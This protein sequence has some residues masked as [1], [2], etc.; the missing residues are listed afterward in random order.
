VTITVKV[1]SLG[2]WSTYPTASELY[3]E[4]S[5]YDSGSDAGRSTVASND[6]LSDI[7]TTVDSDSSSGQKVLNVASTTGFS[8]G[9][10]ILI[11][12]GGAR[13]E[14]G[15]VASIQAGVSL[16]LEDN[17]VYTHTA[18][19]GDDVA[20]EWFDFDVTMTPLRDGAIYINAYLK[21]YEASKGC[22]VNG[23]AVPV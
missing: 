10:E 8:V 21:K 18:A 2:V 13:E 19:Q 4:A 16:T 15:V 11:H 1:R 20:K 17:L 22:Y 23:E 14:R 6:V 9:D 5:Y 7:S 3:I 12:D